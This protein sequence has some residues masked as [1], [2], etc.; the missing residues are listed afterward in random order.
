MKNIETP[1]QFRATLFEKF[2]ENQGCFG[3][4]FVEAIKERDSLI[5]KQAL[6]KQVVALEAIINHGMPMHGATQ[7]TWRRAF[8][9]VDSIA[10]KAL[11]ES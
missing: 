1:D 7:A 10:R 5:L 4:S 9:S 2:V 3:P 8:M 11:K 6:S